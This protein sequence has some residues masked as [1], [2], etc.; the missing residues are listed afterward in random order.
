VPDELRC[1]TCRFWEPPDS[2]DCF[3]ECRRRAPL[4]RLGPD[5]ADSIARAEWPSTFDDDWCGEWQP[6]P[7]RQ[8]VEEKG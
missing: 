8:K 7:A 4:P 2:D 5:N 3:G 6:L 1:S